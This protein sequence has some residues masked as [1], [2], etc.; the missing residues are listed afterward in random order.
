[1][2]IPITKIQK[3]SSNIELQSLPKETLM[4]FHTISCLQFGFLRCFQEQL[5]VREKSSEALLNILSILRKMD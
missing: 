5:L 2:I 3:T 4:S 1:M